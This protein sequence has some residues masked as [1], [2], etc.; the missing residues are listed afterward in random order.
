[1]YKY[2]YNSKETFV[3]II[4]IEDGGRM[5]F[6]NFATTLLRYIQEQINLKTILNMKGKKLW[7]KEIFIKSGHAKHINGHMI[8]IW[9]DTG[10]ETF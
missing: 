7:E 3:S 5:T 10:R 9:W 2:Y 8:S 6:R 1:M 4:Y